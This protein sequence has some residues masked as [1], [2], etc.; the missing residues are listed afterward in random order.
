MKK[1]TATQFSF[2]IRKLTAKHDVYT[3]P[4]R[5]RVRS[6]SIANGN[7][8][9]G[10]IGGV[11]AAYIAA[12][13]PRSILIR[14]VSYTKLACVTLLTRACTCNLGSRGGSIQEKQAAPPENKAMTKR[15]AH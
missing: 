1:G 14:P 8:G 9:P 7:N 12:P 2:P 13:W 11:A 5:S 3:N 15:E 4:A 6:R 10:A